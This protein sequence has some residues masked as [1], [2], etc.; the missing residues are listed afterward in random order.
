MS[1]LFSVLDTETIRGLAFYTSVLLTILLVTLGLR[2][3]AAHGLRTLP[4]GPK[5]LPLIGNLVRNNI[6][7]SNLV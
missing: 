1:I 4:P 2:A 5:A 6:H 7:A 3:R